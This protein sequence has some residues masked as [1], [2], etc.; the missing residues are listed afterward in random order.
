MTAREWLIATWAEWAPTLRPG[1]LEVGPLILIT[2]GSLADVAREQHDIGVLA[3]RR[4]PG[5]RL[6]SRPETEQLAEVRQLR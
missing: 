2:R 1:R 5:Q 6:W 3:E 4:E